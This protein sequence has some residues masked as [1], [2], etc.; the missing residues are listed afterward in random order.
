MSFELPAPAEAD[1]LLRQLNFDDTDRLDVLAMLPR[2]AE[3]PALWRLLERAY[4][5]VRTDVGN[6]GVV[7]EPSVVLPPEL[8]DQERYFWI[9]VYLAAVQNIRCW[10]TE[11]RVPDDI[12]WP[13]LADLGRH[14]RLYRRRNGRLGLDT[15]GWMALH[16]RGALYALGRLQ[17]ELRVWRWERVWPGDRVLA[18]HIPESGPLDPEACD[19][20]FAAASEF[21]PR[22][23]PEYASR[24][25]TCS[26]WLLD[27]QLLEYLPQ[28][29]N[30][31]RFQ[32]RF[33]L[34]EGHRDGDESICHFVF[35]KPLSAANQTQPRTTLERAILKHL[36]DGRHWRTRA[37]W[38]VNR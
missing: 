24:V 12:S 19:A 3:Q 18:V 33:E 13:T 23:F 16:F 1:A 17:F 9:F 22:L 30:I 34:L 10:H 11:H 29:S 4:N 38:L 27:D 32:R 7:Q 26:S 2:L 35:S 31:V 14:V 20:S 6:I 5:A 21:F 8:A 36:K 25:A 15:V 37:G 28:D